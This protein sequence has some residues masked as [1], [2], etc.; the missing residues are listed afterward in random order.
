MD[1]GDA[2]RP[3]ERLGCYQ[4]H[5]TL[6]RMNDGARRSE[7]PSA[8]DAWVVVLL[9]GT[10]GVCLFA[11]YAMI[12]SGS[13]VGSVS[14]LL[15]LVGVGLIL[16]PVRYTIAP[17][18][19]VI[20]SG[21]WKIRIPL[22]TIRRAYPSSS[23][24]ASPALSLERLAIEYGSGPQPRSTMYMSPAGRD[25]F[26]DDLAAAARLERRGDELVRSAETSAR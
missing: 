15:L 5:I 10:L 25:A 11:A 22:R 2:A 8:V 26:L 19:L 21:V 18:E 3:L 17:D 7:Y 14:L 13:V 1:A 24:L 9:A 23:L 12:R 4:L 6:T 20:R 16:M